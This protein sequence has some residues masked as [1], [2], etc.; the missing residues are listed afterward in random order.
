[1]AARLVHT[2]TL[3]SSFIASPGLYFI[4]GTIPPTAL[5][6]TRIGFLITAAGPFLTVVARAAAVTALFTADSIRAPELA[7]EPAFFWIVRGDIAKGTS[8]R[9]TTRFVAAIRPPFDIVLV[10]S[11][12]LAAVVTALRIASPANAPSLFLFHAS[13]LFVPPVLSLFP[14]F[15]RHA[16]L[17]LFSVRSYKL[18]SGTESQFP[19]LIRWL[20]DGCEYLSPEHGSGIDGDVS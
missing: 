14:T 12:A 20:L 17:L 11:V 1:M 7:S 8:T 16:A 5:S 3:F 15:L 2:T 10:F 6:S 13:T 4:L 18:N 9:K 19:L